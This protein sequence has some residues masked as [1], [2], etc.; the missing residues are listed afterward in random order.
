MEFLRTPMP[1]NSTSTILPFCKRLYSRM[2]F[3]SYCVFRLLDY[4][5]AYKFH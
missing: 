5:L 2:S 1:L 3:R 4:N